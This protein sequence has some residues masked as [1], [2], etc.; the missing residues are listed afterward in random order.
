MEQQFLYSDPVIDGKR[1]HKSFG[2]VSV[3]K[4][5]NIEVGLGE[6]LVLFGGNGSGKT[7]LIRAL[8]TLTRLDAGKIK[9]AGM[10]I[11]NQS[12][13]VRRS[14]GV[15]THQPIIYDDLTGYENLS[16]YGKMYN[17]QNIPYR[18]EVLSEQMRIGHYLD[19]K[20]R[21]L[22]FGIQKRFSLVRALIHDPAVLLL[23]EPDTGLDQEALELLNS[24][25]ESVPGKP[26]TVLMTS[27]N[28]ERGVLLGDKVAVLSNGCIPYE[29]STSELDLAEFKNVFMSYLG[30]E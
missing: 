22:S 8:A 19:S 11:Q 3:L 25:I 9:I 10:D 28:I 30:R 16:F 20:V 27:H 7:T 29:K 1:L 2:R 5:L 17:L 14:I 26:R 24:L 18:I 12:I 23:D 21:S 6:R 15:V 4:N 13:Q